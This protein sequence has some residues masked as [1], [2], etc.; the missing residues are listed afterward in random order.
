MLTMI[1]LPLLFEIFYNVKGIQLWP[2]RFKREKT[3]SASII[4]LLISFSSFGQT[5]ELSLED[6]IETAIENN[7]ELNAYTL[8]VIGK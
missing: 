4:L 3:I 7:K 1:A 8:K 2:L 5:K 6:A